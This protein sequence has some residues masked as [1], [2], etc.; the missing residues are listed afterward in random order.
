MY[1]TETVSVTLATS[2]ATFVIS[3]PCWRIDGVW[4]PEKWY[5]LGYVCIEDYYCDCQDS[6]D[7]YQRLLE[8]SWFREESPELADPGECQNCIWQTGEALLPCA[9]NPLSYGQGCFEH[10]VN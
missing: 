10:Q 1:I 7:A 3:S 9:V 4:L 6:E 2:K 8:E 5:R